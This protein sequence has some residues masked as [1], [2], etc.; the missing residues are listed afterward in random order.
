MLIRSQNKKNLTNLS[1][2]TNIAIIARDSRFKM[3]TMQYVIVAYYPVEDEYD[4]MGEYST[5]TKA[6]K[7]LDMIQEHYSKHYFSQGAQMATSSAVFQPF[8]F[9][10]PKIFHM[11]TD[12]EV[13][14]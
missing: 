7:V 10:P 2:V 6:I 4:Y 9:I 5:E 11:P 12:E 8:G 14:V 3:D 1:Q 13:E